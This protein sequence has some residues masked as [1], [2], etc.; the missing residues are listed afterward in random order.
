MVDQNGSGGS[1]KPQ[2]KEQKISQLNEIA[3]D[4]DA[5]RTYFP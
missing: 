3:M 5:I 4:R 1:E 2:S